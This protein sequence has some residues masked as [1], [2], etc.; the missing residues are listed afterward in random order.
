M[1]KRPRKFIVKS[2][3]ERNDTARNREQLALFNFWLL[4][5]V[6]PLLGALD[7]DDIRVLVENC[8]KCSEFL[9]SAK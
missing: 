8:K 1:L 2:L 4:V 9:V 3:N 7:D 5:V 6:L